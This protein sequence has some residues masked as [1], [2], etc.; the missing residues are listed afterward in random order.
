M[1]LYVFVSFFVCFHLLVFILNC[2]HDA[3]DQIKK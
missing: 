3:C 2:M 1:G